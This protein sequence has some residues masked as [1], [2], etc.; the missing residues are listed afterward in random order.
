MKTRPAYRPEIDGLRAIAVIA[1]IIYHAEFVLGKT[2]MLPGGF[3]GVDVFFVLSGYLITRLIL[4]ELANKSFSFSSFYM[5][6]ARRLL[7]ILFLVIASCLVVG[8]FIMMPPAFAELSGS[9]FTAMFFG[10]NFWFWLEDDY[11]ASASQIKPL[12]HT[13]SLAVEEQFYLIFPPLLIALH[14]WARRYI[15]VI[16]AG[17]AVLS[18]AIAVYSAAAQ[19]KFGFYLLPARFWEILCGALLAILPQRTSQMPQA[20]ANFCA[21]T[22]LALIGASFALLSNTT[23]HPSYPAIAAVAGTMLV[24]WHARP[25]TQIAKLLSFSPLVYIG[26]LSYSLYLW[27]FPA[28]AFG[29]IINPDPSIAEKLLWLAG[30]VLIS[31]FGYHLVENP[32]RRRQITPRALLPIFAGCALAIS[33]PSMVIFSTG[34]APHRLGLSAADTGRDEF[35]NA[36][37]SCHEYK[38]PCTNMGTRTDGPHFVLVGDSLAGALSGSLASRLLKYGRYS[39]FTTGACPH[40]VGLTIDTRPENFNK[41]CQK[42]A[43]E[44]RNFVLNNSDL[45][46]IHLAHYNFWLGGDETAPGAKVSAV[47][48]DPSQFIR[49]ALMEW[50]R[51]GHR[52]IFVLQPP[53]FP[54]NF[55]APYLGLD[56]AKSLLELRYPD[57]PVQAAIERS[58]P[59]KEM[60]APIENPDFFVFDSL[61]IFCTDDKC[62]AVAEQK[63]L[64]TDGQHLSVNG[65]RLFAD[66]FVDWLA[67]TIPSQE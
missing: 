67:S 13:W 17:L 59:V 21:L 29:R 1:V 14:R 50:R 36:G 7:P 30:A 31:I 42:L 33:I 35:V 40:I 44:F 11:W 3:L 18:F 57:E 37:K 38:E 9:A 54:H 56:K 65:S 20:F 62:R 6:R 28:F 58:A 51:N 26:L 32:M 34:G 47:G 48:A 49:E 55:D 2:A 4:A 12:L 22:G 61:P 52:V 24:V 10:A 45:T 66:A 63:I 64:Y 53:E 15:L 27:H 43:A 5:R 8:W 16:F 23:P 46:I 39:Q 41:Y 60:L 25:G 19:P